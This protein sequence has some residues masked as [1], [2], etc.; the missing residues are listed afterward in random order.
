MKGLLAAAIL[1]WP[2]FVLAAGFQAIELSEDRA[3]LVITAADGQQF[4]APKF[5]EQV[6]FGRPRVS[7]DGKYV[8]WLALFPN[9]CTSYPIPLKL[10]VL[11]QSRQL[12]SF[13]GIKISIFAWC[14]SP[15]S[16]SVAYRQGVLHGSDFRHFELR[17][18]SGGRLLAEYDYPHEEAENIHARK[19][20]PSWV[21]CV[22]E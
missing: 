20:A 10:V 18:I 9:C 7:A 11:D 14:F 17:S 21:H 8:G 3:R 22:P 6:E 2:I 19:H 12:H 4:D 15:N 13:E 1:V 16:P 5:S